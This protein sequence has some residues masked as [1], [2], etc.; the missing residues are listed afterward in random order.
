MNDILNTIYDTLMQNTQ[1]EQ[2][3]LHALEDT[4]ID[5]E[6]NTITLEYK[7]TTYILTITKA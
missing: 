6:T 5:N 3:N 2:F 7:D 1:H 4:F